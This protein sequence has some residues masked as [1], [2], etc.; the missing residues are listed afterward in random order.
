VA[1]QVRGSVISRAGALAAE[2]QALPSDA[3]T[4]GGLLVSCAPAALDDVLANCL[5]HGFAQAAGVGTIVATRAT[6]CPVV[7]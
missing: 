7:R 3:Q 1:H 6:P 5:R 2:D 4:R